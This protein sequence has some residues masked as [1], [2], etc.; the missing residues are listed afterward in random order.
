MIVPQ[1]WAEAKLKTIVD[2][3][4]IT[5]KRFGW[6]DN[7]ESDAQV[8]AQKRAEEA[9]ALAQS[10]EKVRKIDHKT[11]YNGAE[12]LPIR[13]E[14]I[15]RHNDCVITRNTYGALCIN[16]PDVLFAD[17]DFQYEPGFWFYVGN[18]FILTGLALLTG[19]HYG[20]W[21]TFF[22][23]V[24]ASIL[25]TSTL[26]GILFKGLTVLKGGPVKLALKPIRTFSQNHPNWHLRLYKTPMG[27]RVLVM[28]KT[29]NPRS[30]E[31]IGFMRDLNSD[32]N[33]IRMCQNQNCFRARISP[34]PWRIGVNRLRPR[35]GIWPITPERMPDRRKWVD[36][37]EKVALD[38]ASCK[39]MEHLGS[40]K[41]D[42]KA[43]FVRAI[44]D[45]Y[46]RADKILR[47]A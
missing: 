13:E 44:H 37:Y 42:P 16:T 45:E 12:G 25:F 32:P 17:I 34:K 3:K 19:L 39:F 28:H 43:E 21:K 10:G 7:S 18:F 9:I 5:I 40:N 26:A 36:R 35:P 1:Y 15:S 41:T 46:C 31:A 4:R 8:N 14:I 6:S 22:F 33:Y 23:L 47:L 38:Y 27:Y 11:P 24:F 20:S 2:G 29:F 30:D